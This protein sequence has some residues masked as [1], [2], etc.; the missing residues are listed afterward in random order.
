M[1]R[2]EQRMIA[3]ELHYERGETM[4]AVARRLNV[5][6]STISRL[7]AEAREF[8]LVQISLRR[9]PAQDEA[10]RAI[11]ERF[12]IEVYGVA[13]SEA[14]E[15]ERL[16]R[17]TKVAA[18]L[19]M[20]NVDRKSGSKI[21]LAWG[22]TVNTLV[23]QLKP[24]PVNALIVQLN[25]AANPSTTGIPLAGATL[26]AAANAFSGSM[27]HFPVPAFFD[28]AATREAMWA[29]RSIKR[30]L[31]AQDSIDIAVFSVGVFDAPVKSRVYSAG[32]LSAED[33]Q[34]LVDAGVVGDVC[35]VMLR[36]D[37][38]YEGIE[39]NER[40]SGMAPDRLR[41]IPER[42]CV[43]AGRAK[44]EGTLAA[45]RAGLVTKLVLDVELAEAVVAL[46]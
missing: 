38:S 35:T 24:L 12:G 17:V 11:A 26:T 28:H 14:S 44:A 1:D 43:C 41:R 13:V 34:E 2:E 22:T 10:S 31:A 3:A 7:L 21:G 19:L 40:A 18:D 45:I 16:Q 20:S 25:G 46:I 36:A 8:G 29:E 6:R 33:V 9:P 42:I 5:S 15:V 37:G 23:R 30:V 32:Y 39:L 27:M 4:E